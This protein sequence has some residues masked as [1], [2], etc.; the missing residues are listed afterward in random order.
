MEDREINGDFPN[1]AIVKIRKP[2]RFPKP[3]RFDVKKIVARAGLKVPISNGFALPLNPSDKNR[4][5]L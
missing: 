1:V 2:I 3:Y 4:S 5:R